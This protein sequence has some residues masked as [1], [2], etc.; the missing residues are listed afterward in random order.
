MSE[1]VKRIARHVK[2]TAGLYEPK[3]DTV[4]FKGDENGYVIVVSYNADTT[5]GKYEDV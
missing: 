5:K 4:K 3:P 1:Q 2:Q